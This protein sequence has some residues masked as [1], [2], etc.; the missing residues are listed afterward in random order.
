MRSSQNLDDVV[1]ERTLLVHAYLDDELDAARAASIQSEILKDP[2]VKK[3][4]EALRALR[5]AVRKQLAPPPVPTHFRSR[6]DAAI[7]RPWYQSRPTWHALA[8]SVVGA[9]LLTGG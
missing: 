7:S 8:A 1:D 9:A 3:E 6:L 5:G 4:V 2:V